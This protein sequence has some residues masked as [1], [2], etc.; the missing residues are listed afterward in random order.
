MHRGRRLVGSLVLLGV[1]I[2]LPGHDARAAEGMAFSIPYSDAVIYG[3]V[4]LPSG[5]TV[6]FGIREGAMLTIEHR[7]E[8]YKFGASLILNRPLSRE[9]GK[10]SVTVFPTRIIPLGDAAES[11]KSDPKEAMVVPFGEAAWLEKIQHPFQIKVERIEFREFGD[12]GFLTQLWDYAK[13]HPGEELPGADLL[14]SLY[15]Q[16]PPATTCIICGSIIVCSTDPECGGG[17]QM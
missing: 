2:F 10:N 3:S 9:L 1:V 7:T 17:R 15:G 12:A 4:E 6:R 14:E 16:K 5:E 13:A 11:S 8:G